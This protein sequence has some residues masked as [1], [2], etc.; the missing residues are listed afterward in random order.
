MT[1]HLLVVVSFR[2]SQQL[3]G[4]SCLC[5]LVPP[6][7]FKTLCEEFWF[8]SHDWQYF[9]LLT[10]CQLCETCLPSKDSFIQQL[11]SD[12]SKNPP[13][14][15]GAILCEDTPLTSPWWTT[16]ISSA[17]SPLHFHCSHSLPFPELQ[18]KMHISLFTLFK[19]LLHVGQK[20]TQKHD[21][22]GFH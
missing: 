9:T 4:Y 7:I 18:T 14:P 17:P 20:H 12:H 2:V 13:L 1:I 21:R 3:P 22:Q 19:N 15:T 6:R 5:R 16:F 11:L 10:L 8:H